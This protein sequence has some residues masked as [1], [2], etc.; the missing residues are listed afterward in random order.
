[1]DY[2]PFGAA[3]F[4]ETSCGVLDTHRK[5]EAMSETVESGQIKRAVLKNV[6]NGVSPTKARG[7]SNYL[8]NGKIVH[9]RFCRTNNKSP[10]LFKFNINPNTLKADYELWICGEVGMYYLIPTVVMQRIYDD[11]DT[12]PDNTHPDIRVVS[13]D[14]FSDR[15]MYKTGGGKLD[16]A[17]YRNARL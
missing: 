8:V 4:A 16:I 10:N 14:I 6:G 2:R 3:C 15:V 11:P 13:V 9:A 12:Y 7:P 17:N 5:E 1:M